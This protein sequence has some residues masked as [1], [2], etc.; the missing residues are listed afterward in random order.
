R[1]NQLVRNNATRKK[2]KIKV[3]EENRSD[4]LASIRV[5]D[6]VYVL[7]KVR[8]RIS[9][10][11]WQTF[12]NLTQLGRTG[13]KSDFPILPTK[14]QICAVKGVIFRATM[15]TMGVKDLPDPIE[16]GQVSLT[17]VL[18]RCIRE[19]RLNKVDNIDG[20]ELNFNLNVQGRLRCV[21]AD[22]FVCNGKDQISFGIVPL[23]LS[24]MSSQSCKAVFPIAISNCSETR[25]NIQGMIQDILVEKNAI[26][27]N[28]M[29][30][31]GRNYIVNFTVTLDYKA[32][33]L[34]AI[35]KEQMTHTPEIIL[36]GRGYG[37]EFCIFC[38]AIRGCACPGIPAGDTCAACFSQSKGNIGNWKGICDDLTLLLEEDMT[39]VNLCALHCEMRNTE[40]L[41][42]SIGLFA[43]KIGSLENLNDILREL[44]PAAMKKDF[45][46]LR[47]RRNTNLAVNKNHIKVASLSGRVLEMKLFFSNVSRG[48]TYNRDYGVRQETI[49][50]LPSSKIEIYASERLHFWD[51]M[52][53]KI[54]EFLNSSEECNDEEN[55][56]DEDGDDS[57]ILFAAKLHQELFRQ[58]KEWGLQLR[59]TFGPLLGT[60]DYG[61][62]VIEHASMLMRTFG[63]MREFS[64]QGFESSHKVDRRLYQQATNHDMHQK[65]SSVKQVLVHN[66][67]DRLLFLRM[68][69]EKAK[70]CS[71]HD[72]EFFF[73]GCGWK[74]TKVK[75]T[76]DDMIFDIRY[77][78]GYSIRANCWKT[79][80]AQTRSNLGRKTKMSQVIATKPCEQKQAPIKQL[81]KHKMKKAKCSLV[82]THAEFQGSSEDGTQRVLPVPVWGGCAN[83]DGNIAIKL[84]NTCPI[85]NYL[86]I[87]YLYLKEHPNVLEQLELSSAEYAKRLVQIVIAFDAQDFATGKIIWLRQ[88]PNF[89][90][91]ASRTVDVWGCELDM[92]FADELRCDKCPRKERIVQCKSIFIT[93]LNRERTAT[94]SF[95]EEIFN[96]WLSPP[97][98]PCKAMFDNQLVLEANT[99]LIEQYVDPEHQS[100]LC[101]GILRSQTRAFTNG[102]PWVL[103]IFFGDLARSCSELASPKDIPLVLPLLGTR[104]Y[105]GGITFWNGQHYMARLCYH[106]RWFNYDGLATP[107][108]QPIASLL[109]PVRAGF[110]MSSAVYFHQ[111]I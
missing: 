2:R 47:E 109:V 25:K 46:R 57:L 29:Y 19:M 32:L 67:T 39:S 110:I 13:K 81:K 64:N 48:K 52:S 74:P 93:A 106:K 14:Q 84:I 101:K 5:P 49:T 82:S 111:Q 17:S 11:A 70:E 51:D 22:Q 78:D 73:R 40:Q 34:I 90:F 61:H 26:K 4:M 107:T 55:E 96:D 15:T 16:G 102:H 33:I 92:H 60:G 98:Q 21:F 95:L 10:A 8:M 59:E 83:L 35:R 24:Y 44:G 54:E 27:S 69:F 42:G 43:Y 77:D 3:K 41:L 103:P 12:I 58:C 99:E 63:S 94:R 72:R 45:V 20:G 18:A 31:D 66:Y 9:D 87:F 85:D 89:D 65:D 7:A 88:F 23:H 62:L 1:N 50:I 38:T 79:Y 80:L 86:T 28:G 6:W 108:L 37:V 104:Y 71:K 105:L 76:A 91:S 97:S 30:V 56:D 53:K 75:W 68:C 36:G 100:M